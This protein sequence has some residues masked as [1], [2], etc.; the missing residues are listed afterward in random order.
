MVANGDTITPEHRFKADEIAEQ[1]AAE[2]ARASDL[3][4]G[5]K[6]TQADTGKG[7]S[8]ATRTKLK[9]S[10]NVSEIMQKPVSRAKDAPTFEALCESI[11][12]THAQLQANQIDQITG[13]A[14]QGRA[15]VQCKKAILTQ[16]QLKESDEKQVSREFGKKLK[17]A[18]IGDDVIARQA[19]GIY[20]WLA[21]NEKDAHAFLQAAIET[22]KAKRTPEQKRVFNAHARLGLTPYVLQAA[23]SESAPKS[24]RTAM[25]TAKAHIKQVIKESKADKNAADYDSKIL[26]AARDLLSQALAEINA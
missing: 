2:K 6:N 16:K 17:E 23:M 5:Q 12:E 1:K 15:L 7:K 13:F 8:R 3:K 10:V 9:N 25:D 18:G 14:K 21:D 26:E 11:K 22:E 24:E 4:Q 19:R 20:I